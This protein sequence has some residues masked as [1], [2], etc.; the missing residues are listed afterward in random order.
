MGAKS[1]GFVKEIL[2]ASVFGVSDG[3][4][5]YLL[6][7]VLIGFPLSILLNAIQTVMISALASARDGKGQGVT[8]VSTTIVTLLAIG[9]ILPVWLA[10]LDTLL[11]YVASSFSPE[12][13]EWL[14]TALIWLIP[15]YFLNGA[16]LLGY[17]LLQARGR[18]FA[19]G[20]LPAITPLVT[21]PIIYFYARIGA[22]EALVIALTVGSLLESVVVNVLL[23]RAGLL[24]RPN[25][26]APELVRV[27]RGSKALLPGTLILAL[28]MVAEQAIAASLGNGAVAAL[29]YG[30]RLPAALN[31]IVVTAIGITVLPYFASLLAEGKAAYCLHSLEKI[32]RW[33]LFLGLLLAVALASMSETIVGVIYQRGAFDTSAAASVYPIQQAYF[34]Q[35]PFYLVLV[36]STRMLAALGRNSVVSVLAVVAVSIQIALAWS[37]GTRFGPAGIAWAATFSYAV[38]AGASFLWARYFLRGDAS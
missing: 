8:Y 24:G 23:A 14:E 18:F 13:L 11:P 33:L 10:V 1:I 15:Y 4:D 37:L 28:G 34:F 5:V 21:I 30:Y 36:L 12:K 2:V 3:L 25:F 27:L 9:V 38:W 7:F 22:W 19:N 16:N 35:L 26:H 29:G 20:L 6:A 17:G 31:G 32:A